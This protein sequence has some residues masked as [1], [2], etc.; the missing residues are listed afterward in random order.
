M[1][2]RTVR[3]DSLT[4]GRAF[5]YRPETDEWAGEKAPAG[6]PLAD[7]RCVYRIEQVGDRTTAISAA[8]VRTELAPDT[9]VVEVPRAGWETVAKK[10]RQ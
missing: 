10:P 2:A 8:G 7:P 3:L 4:V 5:F 6:G 1:S 9:L